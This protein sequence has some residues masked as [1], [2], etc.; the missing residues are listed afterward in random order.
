[1]PRACGG[2]LGFLVEKGESESRRLFASVDV[3]HL[4]A[5][6]ERSITVAGTRLAAHAHPTHFRVG[7]GGSVQLSDRV[8]VLHGL[9]GYSAS[10][11]DN[12]DFMAEVRMEIRF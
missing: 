3:E 6:A 10:G 7:L 12:Q 1:M 5:G 11:K 8:P 9:L 4:F 2:R